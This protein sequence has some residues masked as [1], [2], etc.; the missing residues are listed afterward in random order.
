M[1]LGLAAIGLFSVM[2]WGVGVGE[3]AWEKPR[4][5]STRGKQSVK[6]NVSCITEEIIT[7]SNM[8]FVNKIY[9]SVL[10]YYLR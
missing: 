7:E 2:G 5:Q 3:T 4:G 10:K 1:S 9:R 8:C 6:K